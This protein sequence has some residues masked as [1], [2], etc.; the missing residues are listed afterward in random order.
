[1]YRLLPA[2]VPFCAERFGTGAV[3]GFRVSAWTCCMDCTVPTW[4]TGLGAETDR[5]SMDGWFSCL[6]CILLSKICF[7]KGQW[8]GQMYFAN[9]NIHF[10]VTQDTYVS[11]S[12]SPEPSPLVLKMLCCFPQ[13]ALSTASSCTA[14]CMKYNC[15]ACRQSI[16]TSELTFQGCKMEKSLLRQ[17]SIVQYRL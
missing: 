4:C 3:I 13:T 8:S 10:G 16:E 6:T 2:A 11:F 7:K 12:T 9:E 1:M 17:A 5:D 14:E 15:T